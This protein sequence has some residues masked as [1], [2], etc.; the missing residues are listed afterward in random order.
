MSTHNIDADESDDKVVQHMQVEV[1]LLLLLPP[2]ADSVGG[3]WTTEFELHAAEEEFEV[4][5]LGLQIRAPE[6]RLCP[7]IVEVRPA[8]QEEVKLLLCEHGDIACELCVVCCDDKCCLHGAL[9]PPAPLL[10]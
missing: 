9:D 8:E 4:V 7:V 10:G 6:E 1:L 2:A 3:W 5:A